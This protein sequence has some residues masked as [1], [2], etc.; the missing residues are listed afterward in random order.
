MPCPP[1]FDDLYNFLVLLSFLGELAREQEI[2]N[3]PPAGE[4]RLHGHWLERPDRLPG[5]AQWIRPVSDVRVHQ[6]CAN[7]HDPPAASP[8]KGERRPHRAPRE[9]PCPAVAPR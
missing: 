6:S 4:R 7:G 3:P 8:A 5:P 2:E 9:K 1:L